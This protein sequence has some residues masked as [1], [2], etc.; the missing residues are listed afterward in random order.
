MAERTERET[1]LIHRCCD[2]LEEIEE[3]EDHIERLEEIIE[4]GNTSQL[5]LKALSSRAQRS[6][7]MAVRISRKKDLQMQDLNAKNQ[8][9]MKD[10][11][12]QEQAFVD[13][14]AAREIEESLNEGRD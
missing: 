9:L 8:A 10:I 1:F 7:K 13:R 3:L 12:H 2:L 11:L 5:R 14:E 6:M 4:N